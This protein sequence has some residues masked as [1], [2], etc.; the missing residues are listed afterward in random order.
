M[1]ILLGLGMG[2]LR[3]SMDRVFRTSGQVEAALQTSCLAVVPAVKGRSSRRKQ[4][5]SA[6]PRTIARYANISWEVIERPLSRFAE[7]MRSIKSVAG[8]NRPPIKVLG[9]T[10]ALPSEGKSTIGT[11][12]ALLIAQPGTRVILVDCDLRHPA[13]S[14][15]L[16]P[17]AEHG[18]LDVVSG[19]KQLEDVLWTDEM[20]NLSF[21]PGAVKSAIADSAEVLASEA[22]RTFFEQ[23]RKQYDYVVVDLPP[24]AP[25]VDVR[26]TGG[27]V[28]SYVFIVEWGRTKMEVVDLA[29]RKT[30]VVYENLL[31]VV[32][33]KVD[34]KMLG[35]YEGH[36]RDYYSDKYY[37]QY[38]DPRS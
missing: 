26:S 3:V 30:P 34:F 1:D 28:D 2:V 12:F 22:L 13:L 11:A 32:L 6:R 20:T 5:Q 27:L 36:R 16:A 9:F 35:R 10:S 17:G 24:V 31:G 4:K 23:L 18:L 7:A 14:K 19:K 15:T 33:N 37:A 8:L 29:L 21:L 38:G 25:I